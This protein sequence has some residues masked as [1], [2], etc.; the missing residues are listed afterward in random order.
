MTLILPILISINLLNLNKPDTSV[1]GM[2]NQIRVENGLSPVKYN[3]KLG[4]SAMARACDMRDKNYIK[5][6]SPDGKLW[7]FFYDASY[8][9]KSAGENLAKDCTDS[10]CVK[11]WMLSP[12]HK[13]IILDPRFKEGGV[14]R[15]GNSL[16]LHVGTR[17]T[18]KEKLKIMIFRVKAILKQE[19][20]LN[21]TNT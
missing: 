3:R 1:L 21:T 19:T 12:K 11:L 9:F 20:I 14:S 10:D 7:E 8:Y 4:K 16:V 2:V 15:C 5:H 13:E 6:I 18:I 17:L